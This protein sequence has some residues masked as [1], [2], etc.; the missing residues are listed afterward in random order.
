MAGFC[1]DLLQ[2]SRTELQVMA[3]RLAEPAET[4]RATAAGVGV[5]A[6]TVQR[7]VRAMA[8]RWPEVAHL[9][10]PR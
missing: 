2:C 4:T 6:R 9:F 1:L 7:V 10:A 5:S 3:R 8:V